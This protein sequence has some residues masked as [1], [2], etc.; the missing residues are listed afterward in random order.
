MLFVVC[1]WAIRRQM[2]ASAAI[3]GISI[4]IGSLLKLFPIL[5]VPWLMLRRPKAVMWFAVG[6]AALTLLSVAVAGWDL[7]VQFVTQ[8]LPV[9]RGTA[10][11]ENQS[12]FGF[13]ARLWVDGTSVEPLSATDS[14]L[15]TLLSLLAGILTY[16]L[17]LAV[18]L[19]AEHPRHAFTVLVPCMLLVSPVAWIH[20]EVLLLLPIGIFLAGLATRSSHIAWPLLLF[21]F[22]LLAFGNEGLFEQQVWF[23]KSGIIQ[24]YKFF[25][26]FAMWLLGMLWAWYDQ[27]D[28]RN[29]AGQ[30]AE[31]HEHNQP[32]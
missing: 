26:V 2:A 20:Y 9:L 7:Q 11:L 14:P 22:V 31:G 4:A 17:S 19:R 18:A 21:A 6:L 30:A 25:G 32:R 24:S 10:Y 1:Y 29:S 12:Y 5:F 23:A 16:A 13:F 15:A 28:T 8:V 27:S 3:S